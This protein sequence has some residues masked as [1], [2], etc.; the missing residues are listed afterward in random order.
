VT[1]SGLPFA[2]IEN[3]YLRLD[4][5]TTTGP[6]IVGLYVSGAEGNLLASTPEVHW[7]TPHG[8]YYLHG[9]HRLWT[10]PE[11]PFYTCP[12]NGLDVIEDRN[13][14][15]LK[16]PVD[17][18]G[19]EK[20]IA[21]RLNKD[22]VHLSHRITWHGG[23]SIEQ[24]PWAI[25]QLRLGGMAILP[26]S[27]EQEGLSPNRNIVFWPY[28]RI[29]DERL[30]M[31]DDLILLYGRSDEHA[32]KI[33]NQNTHGWIACALGNALFVK[34]FLPDTK[35]VYPDMGC[36]VEAYVRDVCIELETLGV[37]KTLKHGESVTH[38]ETWQVFAGEY[39]TNLESARKIKEQF[40]QL[41]IHGAYN[42]KQNQLS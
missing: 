21:I 2:S 32:L 41:K 22:C 23:Q 13:S 12:E 9:G 15:I 8:E 27:T 16:S 14:V 11:N 1:Y 33:G 29:H 18:S 34:W 26:L 4:Y 35:G 39:P 17:D 5:L 10:A 19:L 42:G 28:S 40:S 6:R 31:Q 38:E 24:A 20:E 30:E 25:T 36:N 37:L 7:E 3:E